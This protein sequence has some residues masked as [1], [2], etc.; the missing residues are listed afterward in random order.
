ME[1]EKDE[2]SDVTCWQ[3]SDFIN[4]FPTLMCVIKEIKEKKQRSDE[5]SIIEKIISSGN[6]AIT[7]RD[8]LNNIFEYATGIGLC[9]KIFL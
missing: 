8:T 4:I 1:T 2:K 7:D 6:K 3:C 5:D 9:Q